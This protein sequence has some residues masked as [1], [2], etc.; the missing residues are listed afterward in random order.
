MKSR[1]GLAFLL[2]LAQCILLECSRQGADI[3]P[4]NGAQFDAGE[5][6]DGD[7]ASNVDYNRL[8]RVLSL[9]AQSDEDRDDESDSDSEDSDRTDSSD[10]EN[11]D[12]R[13]GI[14]AV[15]SDD[16]ESDDDDDDVLDAK[17]PERSN[18]KV[19]RGYVPPAIRL[20]TINHKLAPVAS[21][22][23]VSAP[24][25]RKPARFSARVARFTRRR[26][27]RRYF[28]FR[29]PAWFTRRRRRRFHFFWG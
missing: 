11:E 6:D 21:F 29:R 26:R 3:A 27:R 8:E 2:V 9:L 12:E 15:H 7:V 23:P 13:D 14:E 20:R 5:D 22:K 19:R 4:E 24:N 1:L 10:N 25:S 28:Y 18:W 16:N 17:A